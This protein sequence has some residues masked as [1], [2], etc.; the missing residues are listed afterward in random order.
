[1]ELSNSEGC[2][3]AVVA[4]RVRGRLSRAGQEYP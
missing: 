1:M 3:S 2:G 4:S